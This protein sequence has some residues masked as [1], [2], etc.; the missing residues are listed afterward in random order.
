MG[1]VSKLGLGPLFFQCDRFLTNVEIFF[2]AGLEISTRNLCVCNFACFTFFYF[3]KCISRNNYFV[4][5]ERL[6]TGRS[7]DHVSLSLI[8]NVMLM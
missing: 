2:S 8:C 1:Y 5:Y 4:F 6:P 3:G 7:V